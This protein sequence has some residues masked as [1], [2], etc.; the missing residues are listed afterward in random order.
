MIDYPVIRRSVAIL[1]REPWL[2]NPPRGRQAQQV[3]ELS[4]SFAM[5]LRA[6][7]RYIPLASKPLKFVGYEVKPSVYP[8]SY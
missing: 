2:R 5:T 8:W 6:D 1:A 4:P 3:V 7:T